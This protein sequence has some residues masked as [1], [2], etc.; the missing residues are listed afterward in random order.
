MKSHS[1]FLSGLFISFSLTLT[2]CGGGGGGGSEGGGSTGGGN[3]GGGNTGGGNNNDSVTISGVV[4]GIDSGQVGISNSGSDKTTANPDQRFNFSIDEG[5][6]YNIVVEENP[7]EQLCQVEN[8]S[9]NN[10]D[11]NVEN[12][13]VRC[14]P[15]ALAS[16]C[17]G[18]TD[19]DEDGLS[20]CDEL[21]LHYTNPWLA[22]TDGDSYEDG[23]EVADYD[24]SNN[25]FIFNPRV[26][27]MANIAVDLTSVPEVDLDFTE[28]TGSSRSVSTT[29]EESESDN[30]TRNWGGE[31]S[32]QIEVGHT[33]SVSNT[34]TVG[35][36]VHASL[37]DIGGSVSYENSLTVGFE[38]SFSQTRGSSVNWSNAASEE[39]SQTYAET[40]DLTEEQGSTYNGG[41]LR[42]TARIRNDGHIPYDL[43]NLTLSA[44]L[45]D[46]KRPFDIESIGTMEFS[47]GGFPLTSI[48]SGESAPLNF[49]T[50]LTLGKAQ[51]LLRDSENIVIMPG[52]YRLLDID[53]QSLLLVD[54]DVSARTATISIDYG[55]DA[56]REDK[57]RV[58]VNR[59]DGQRSISLADALENVLGLNVMEGAGTWTYGDDDSASTTAPGLLQIGSYTMSNT[60]NRY[61]LVAHNHNDNENSGQ[62]VTDFYNI[63]LDGYD[64]SN[65]SLRADDKISLVYVGDNDRDSISDRLERELGTDRARF[66]TDED[67][68]GDGLEVYG[69]LSN[70]DAQPCDEGDTLTRVFSNPL[71][72]D[73]DEDGVDDLEEKDNCQNPSFNFDVDAGDD[74]FVNKGDAVTLSSQLIQSS[75]GE[76]AVYTWNLTSGPDVFD[77]E[78]NPTRALSGRRPS[79]TAPDEV[80]TLVWE[81]SATLSGETLTDETLVQ[82]QEDVTEAVYVGTAVDGRTE[83]G[84]FSAPFSSLSAAIQSL[85]AGQDVYLM[86][87]AEPYQLVNTL[88]IPDGTSIYG[89]Y[90][91][92]WVRNVE[93]QR[94]MI[95]R[96]TDLDVAV[97]RVDSVTQAMWLS[98]LNVFANGDND[99]ALA[100]PQNDVVALEVIG[101]AST[102]TG[103]LNLRDN[104][105]QSSNVKAGRADNPG[106]SYALRV[107]GLASLRLIDNTLM[108]GNGGLGSHG[109]A[110]SD[111][112]DG[113]D[114]SGR[115]RG[116]GGSGANGGTGGEGGG[117]PLGGGDDGGNGGSVGSASGGAGG[118]GPG[119]CKNATDSG[120][121]GG[122]GDDGNDGSGALQVLYE[123]LVSRY[124]VSS[125]NNGTSGAHAAGG[126]G[127]AGGGGCG[128]ARGGNGGGGGEGGEAGTRGFGGDGGG[129]SVAL[130]LADVSSAEL[131]GNTITSAVGG[132]AG[133]GGRGGAG[134]DGGSYASGSAGSENCVLGLCDRGG[135][136]SRGGNGGNGGDGGHGGGGAGGPSFGIFV[137]ANIAPLLFDNTIT[138]GSGGSGGFSYGN[139]GAGGDSFAI[140]DADLADGATPEVNADNTLAAGSAGNGGSTSGGT[141]GISGWSDSTNF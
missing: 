101:S 102:N 45:F 134:G 12:V 124:T 131:R 63:L 110:G 78:G 123:D 51:K 115:T 1:K 38:S 107:N 48:L 116:S 16:S 121:R 13:V 40:V 46:P 18:N 96:D 88:T 141:A 100:T 140:F 54:R 53:D 71:V 129:A 50:E 5:D 76:T 82:V 73:S 47:D 34:Q 112:D 80:S 130:W 57:F 133:A 8:G 49:S 35:A 39:N 7:I 117:G 9:G 41:F 6:S 97:L 119:G 58:S 99:G 66:D 126:G 37:T 137:G 92:D 27:D 125:G 65:I 113:G 87:Q 86:S 122:D 19:S 106:S 109:T 15:V 30:I 68:L 81:V 120:N 4:E 55:I 79:F 42:V 105:L 74:Q 64:L 67:E 2:A 36:E 23:R 84:S 59:G 69:W 60:T 104:L 98:G 25:R 111:G 95:Q 17:S 127:G 91:D 128:T 29:Y 62:R 3:T 32:R 11:N 28:S 20:D 75:N 61:W 77:D 132:T 70:L 136:G 26:A 89:G 139:A 24:S 21:E 94:T 90:D 33:L 14:T 43:E 22:D 85:S 135:S 108:A 114:A 72:A 118:D 10:I 44:V 31:S 56:A 52:T 138:S 103:T 83:D 93:T